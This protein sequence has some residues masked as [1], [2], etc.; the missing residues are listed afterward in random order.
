M[1]ISI[2]GTNHNRESPAQESIDFGW[3]HLS[4]DQSTIV[5]IQLNTVVANAKE[6]AES[7]GITEPVCCLLHIWIGQYW[8]GSGRGYGFVR[9]SLFSPES[10]CNHDFAGQN[11]SCARK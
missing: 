6:H 4:H 5:R 1:G 7:K 11:G 3:S 9:V 2:F 10:V 8:N